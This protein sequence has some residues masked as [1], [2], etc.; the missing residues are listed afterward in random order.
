MPKINPPDRAV[1]NLMV[2]TLK[3][4]RKTLINKRGRI[5]AEIAVIENQ[6]S[7]M[8]VPFEDDEAT[9]TSEDVENESDDDEDAA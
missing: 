5:D 9:G 1:S 7:G 3:R 6:L 2:N 8:G 4:R